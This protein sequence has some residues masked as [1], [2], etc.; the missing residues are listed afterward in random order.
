MWA[1]AWAN[2]L[3]ERTIWRQGPNGVGVG[4][5]RREHSKQVAGLFG[6]TNLDGEAK[7]QRNSDPHGN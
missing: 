1:I 3:V 4:N 6:E 5:H 2:A 7:R